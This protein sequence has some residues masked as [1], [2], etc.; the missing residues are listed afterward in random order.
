MLQQLKVQQNNQK[1][2]HLQLHQ[3]Q[4][5]HQHNKTLKQMPQR[6]KVQQN[7]QKKSHLQLRLQKIIQLK[8]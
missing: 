4:K 2:S 5:N 8:N 3:Q 6:H 7:N 1:K